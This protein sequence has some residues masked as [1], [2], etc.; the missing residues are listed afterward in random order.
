MAKICRNFS[1]SVR[2][3]IGPVPGM[4][5]VCI[6][7]DQG[8]RG[9]RGEKGDPG[10]PAGIATFI[11]LGGVADQNFLVGQA[12][13]IPFPMAIGGKPPYTR[14]ATGVPDGVM[15]TDSSM[16]VTGAPTAKGESE[17]TLTITDSE[18]PKATAMT[19]FIL[20]VRSVVT[21]PDLPDLN[22]VVGKMFSITLPRGNDGSEMFDKYTHALP[23]LS[24]PYLFTPA[25]RVLSG[26]P[27]QIFGKELTYSVT[28][29][30]PNIGT[31]VSKMVKLCIFTNARP[32]AMATAN[33]SKTASALQ[34]S[35]DGVAIPTIFG[36]GHVDPSISSAGKLT[37]NVGGL[38][39]TSDVCGQHSVFDLEWKYA[40]EL[41]NAKITGLTKDSDVT[42]TKLQSLFEVVRNNRPMEII[43][44]FRQLAEPP[45]VLITY[46]GF[47]PVNLP[48]IPAELLLSVDAPISYQFPAAMDGSKAFDTYVYTATGFPSPLE[49]TSSNRTVAGKGERIFQ[50][51]GVYMVTDPNEDVGATDTSPEYKICMITSKDHEVTNTANLD[52]TASLFQQDGDA[53]SL[54][55]VFG[56]G[57]INPTVSST[58]QLTLNET[59]LLDIGAECGYHTVMDLEWQY[60]KGA[61]I[62]QVLG[63]RASAAL[64]HTNLQSMYNL[65]K[66]GSPITLEATFR[67]VTTLPETTT[68]YNGGDFKFVSLPDV[69]DIL[70]T[71]GKTTPITLPAGID[72]TSEIFVYTL[73]TIP[74]PLTFRSSTRVFTGSPVQILARTLTYTVTDPSIELGDSASK[75]VKLCIITT[76]TH[77]ALSNGV[78]TSKSATS[79]AQDSGATVPTAFGSGSMIPAISNAGA[80]SVAASGIIDISDACGYHNVMD[81]DWKLAN[82]KARA[83]IT[84]YAF[85]AA[86]TNANLKA[87]FELMK[88]GTDSNMS[89]ALRQVTELPTT[90]VTYTKPPAIK[91]PSIPNQEAALRVAKKFTLPVATG[92][93]GDFD[94]SVEGIEV[95]DD[96]SY[97]PASRELAVAS[98]TKMFGKTLTYKA[99]DENINDSATAEFGVFRIA[100]PETTMLEAITRDSMNVI[101]S[102][103]IMDFE[104]SIDANEDLVQLLTRTNLFNPDGTSTGEQRRRLT[105]IPIPPDYASGDGGEM[106]LRLRED[107]TV[108]L[109]ERISDAQGNLITN[110]ADI[111]GVIDLSDFG[112]TVVMD[113]VWSYTDGPVLIRQDPVELTA[114][115][116]G[117]ITVTGLNL[118]SPGVVRFKHELL[119]RFYLGRGLRGLCDVETTFR[120]ID[121]SAVS[122]PTVSFSFPANGVDALRSIHLASTTFTAGRGVT[123]FSAK[124]PAIYGGV[125]FYTSITLTRTSGDPLPSW[126]AFNPST[127]ILS[128]TRPSNVAQATSTVLDY[129]TTDQIGSSITVP[130]TVNVEAS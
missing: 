25:T 38:I 126:L 111:T 116:T 128:G 17:I 32:T 36:S 63:Y 4:D 105:A 89:I 74:S 37:L 115:G 8:P 47:T 21:L 127:R 80:L 7:G 124:L 81:I 93:S 68:T 106:N 43:A 11:L 64:T 2:D 41:I 71:V 31:T 24:D 118:T 88:D 40:G 29:P 58:G 59:G 49:F 34:Q 60:A 33:A 69:S 3:T 30:D 23:G 6:P 54:P 108:I 109:S 95:G 5:G 1:V 70:L 26:N 101:T 13:N 46:S 103:R 14:T 99:D 51:K 15:Y 100:D 57:S 125:P 119:R 52:K 65:V 62:L 107:G 45:A 117:K 18:D 129:V 122:T 87:L 42:D 114:G 120:V 104:G 27:T 72:G 19:K 85:G 86:F 90:A 79:L 96:L 92:G 16:A 91:I 110:Y 94:Y 121:T 35:G 53:V 67:Q 61:I 55:A 12:V 22:F 50:G 66:D 28:D 48:D 75:P 39:D 97:T 44:S 84:G 78:N 98:G 113:L 20:G 73:E 56:S 83:Q 82:D 9:F 130:I 76:D 123:N 77:T 112:K 102:T 10:P